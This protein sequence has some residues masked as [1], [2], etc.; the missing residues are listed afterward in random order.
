MCCDMKQNKGWWAGGLVR[1]GG[2]PG[3]KRSVVGAVTTKHG[4]SPVSSL[5]CLACLS[6]P[7]TRMACSAPHTPPLLTV[8]NH[9]VSHRA[10]PIQ[11]QSGK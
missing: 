3:P 4:K 2:D 1:Y 9:T 6:H 5:V 8:L 10:P 11:L 7:L